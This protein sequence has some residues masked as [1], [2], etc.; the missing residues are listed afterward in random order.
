VSWDFTNQKLIAYNAT[1]G[2]LP[3][4]I[5]DIQVG[6]SMIVAYSNVTGFA[7]WNTAGACALIQI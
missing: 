6:N 7:T 2:A 1:P 3:V 5:L 4:K